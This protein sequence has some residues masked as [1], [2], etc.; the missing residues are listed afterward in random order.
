M[1]YL[2][3]Q[4]AETYYILKKELQLFRK[5]RTLSVLINITILINV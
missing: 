1:D 5:L 4:A 3:G 2:F